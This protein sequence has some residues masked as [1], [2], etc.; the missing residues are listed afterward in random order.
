MEKV[1]TELGFKR[2]NMTKYFNAKYVVISSKREAGIHWAAYFKGYEIVS[3]NAKEVAKY[4][5]ANN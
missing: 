4:L 5:A 1:L 3:G 2:V